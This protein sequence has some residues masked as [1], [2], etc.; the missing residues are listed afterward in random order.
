M[1]VISIITFGNPF[2]MIIEFYYK[3]IVYIQKLFIVFLEN[4]LKK[5]H[6]EINIMST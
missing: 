5:K 2:T 3:C 6:S 4:I 1:C